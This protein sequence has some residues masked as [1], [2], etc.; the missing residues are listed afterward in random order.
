MTGAEG[1]THVISRGVMDC[2]A[3]IM[4]LS[5]EARGGTTLARD[6]SPATE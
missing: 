5:E 4:L 1:Q 2:A 3:R 6:Q